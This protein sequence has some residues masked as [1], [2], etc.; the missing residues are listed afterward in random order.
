MPSYKLYYFHVRAR[1][2]P[3][4]LIFA[5]GAVPFE[6]IRVTGEEWQKLK[7]S[8]KLPF[9]QVPILEIDGQCIL[10]QSNAIARFV[11]EE[12][13]LAPTSALGKAQADQ[14]VD[15]VEDLF[16]NFPKIRWEK[17]EAVKEALKKELFDN[18]LPQQLKYFEQ[19]LKSNNGGE[20]YFVG[21][22]LTYAD[23]CFF[24]VCNSNLAH[25]KAE[26]PD[27]LSGFPLLLQLYKKVLN[28]PKILSWVKTREE[29]TI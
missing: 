11:A 21:N 6:D 9:G 28:E 17:D 2:E 18:K 12:V 5:Q 8:G 29:S 26:I 27:E 4:R 3:T 14:I 24:N 20:G 10:A 15:A 13:G 22:K 19:L 23:I 1:A 16:R 25:G 7:S